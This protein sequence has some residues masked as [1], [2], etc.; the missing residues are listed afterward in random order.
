MI[1]VVI[2]DLDGTLLNKQH[3][4]SEYTKTI[5]GNFIIKNI[6]NNHPTGRHHLDAIP[7]IDLG[8]PLYLV[9]SN[10]AQFIHRRKN[11]FFFDIDSESIKS[12]LDL[13]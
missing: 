7:I 11:F 12:V 8:F 13:E 5:F 2:S 3:K 1:K 4:I 10:G 6:D 9:T